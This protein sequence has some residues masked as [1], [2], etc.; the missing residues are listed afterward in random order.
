MSTS[1]DTSHIHENNKNRIWR[2]VLI[3][4]LAVC[5]LPVLLPLAVCLGAGGLGILAVAGAGIAGLA[6]MAPV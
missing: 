6:V 3:V 4:V 5:A 2:T 1:C